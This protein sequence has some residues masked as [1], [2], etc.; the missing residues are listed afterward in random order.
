MLLPPFSLPRDQVYGSVDS[1][2]DDDD[3]ST[4]IS[5][6]SSLFFPI[7]TSPILLPTRPSNA[8]LPD[9]TLPGLLD[10]ANASL[11]LQLLFTYLFSLLALYFA[12]G[13]FKRFIRNRQ[14]FSLELVHSISGR[15][16][17]CSNLPRHLVSPACSL[18]VRRVWLIA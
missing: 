15:T 11:T 3:N 18:L 12:F 17:M 2:P 5:T 8:T 13:N 14:L 4:T 1:H 9:N 10:T 6:T 16:V 7:K